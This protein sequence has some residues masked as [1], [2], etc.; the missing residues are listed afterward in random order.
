MRSLPW[1]EARKK[2]LVGAPGAMRAPTLLYIR[3]TD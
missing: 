3:T 2:E 1:E